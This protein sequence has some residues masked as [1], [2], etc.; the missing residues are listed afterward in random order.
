MLLNTKHFGGIEIDEKGIITF[1]EG[2]PGFEV[3]KKYTIL[4]QTKEESPFRWLQS[5]DN[6]DLAFVIVDPFFIRKDYDINIGEEIVSSLGIENEKD[7]AVYSI[8]VIPEDATKMS[9]NLK[10]PIIINTKSNK[11]AQVV[12]DTE[13]YSV[14]HYILEELRRQEV[15][16]DACSNKEEGTVNN[17]K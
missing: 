6:P 3:S 7:I 9:M 15:A 10:A 14:R 16:G 8:V 4:C 2:L 11:G 1:D 12:L 17:S 13:K 5:V